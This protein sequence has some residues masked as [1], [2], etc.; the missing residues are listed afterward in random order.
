MSEDFKYVVLA[1]DGD[2]DFSDK[3]DGKV[4]EIP[5]GLGAKVPDYMA[6]HFIGDPR[7]LNGQDSNASEQE[8]I[9]VQMRY[10]AFSPQDRE[11]KIPKL[12]IEE[13]EEKPIEIVEP[14]KKVKSKKNEGE[15]EFPDFKK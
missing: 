14:K 8:R 3:F 5:V 10:A 7:I 15:E 11:V 1:N 4:V 12:R 6:Y 2:T 13:I 9:R